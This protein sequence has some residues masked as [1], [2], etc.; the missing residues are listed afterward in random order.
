MGKREKRKMLPV[1]P[2]KLEVE[3]N[4]RGENFSTV[5]T[6]MGFSIK[7]LS[8]KVREHQAVN[9]W[10]V[11][12]LEAVY[13]I[14]YDDYKADEPVKTEC[15]DTQNPSS[16]IPQNIQVDIDYDKLAEVIYKAVYSASYE[17]VKAAWENS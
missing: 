14:K 12:F 13:G 5:A 9:E 1:H 15:A 3:L 2:Y 4:N 11:R 17:A 7:Y 10:D 6:K 8:N 16:A